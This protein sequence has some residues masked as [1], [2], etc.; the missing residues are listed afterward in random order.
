VE[1]G[2]VSNF[3]EAF[4]QYLGEEAPSYVERDSKTTE[5]VIGLALQG[6]GIPVVAHPIRIGLAR[7]VE[8]DVLRRFKDAGLVGLE[9][10]HSD[11]PPALQTYY[12]TLAEE[13][14]LLPTGGSDFHG[15]VKPDI[16]LGTGRAGNVR[17]PL[18]FLDGLRQYKAL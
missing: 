1:K 2:Y 14:E 8:Y 16:E 11:H 9:V 18:A 13:F 6:G 17:A 5:E 15:T 10:C 12:G 7:A 4:R 3:E